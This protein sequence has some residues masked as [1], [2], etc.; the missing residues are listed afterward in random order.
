MFLPVYPVELSR[1]SLVVLK[2][3][4][5]NDLYTCIIKTL[6]AQVRINDIITYYI[7]SSTC[8][9][10]LSHVS[11]ENEKYGKTHCSKPYSDIGIGLFPL[12]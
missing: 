10:I 2:E 1:N 4:Y 9:S 12:N 5:P 11:G 3:K 6:N 8:I 7:Q